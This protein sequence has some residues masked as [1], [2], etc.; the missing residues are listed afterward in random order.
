MLCILHVIEITSHNMFCFIQNLLSD[1][2]RK[3]S[4]LNNVSKNA[5]LYQQ[6]VKVRYSKLFLPLHHLTSR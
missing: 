2:S 3:Q 1:I 4:E 6:A 5:Q